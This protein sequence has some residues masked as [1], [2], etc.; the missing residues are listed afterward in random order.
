MVRLLKVNTNTQIINYSQRIFAFIIVATN[1]TVPDSH[2]S[3]P[4]KHKT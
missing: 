4:S 2:E 3:V 1:K